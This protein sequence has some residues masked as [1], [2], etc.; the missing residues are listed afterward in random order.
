MAILSTV[1]NGHGVSEKHSTDGLIWAEHSSQGI[2]RWPQMGPVLPVEHLA[3]I[4][5]WAQ[6]SSQGI[7]RWPQMGPVL[8]V[9]HLADDLKWAQ[10]N[11]QVTY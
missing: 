3:D 11:W 9:E 10:Y 6:Q 8:P 5:Q 7:L 4:V 2:L 1:L